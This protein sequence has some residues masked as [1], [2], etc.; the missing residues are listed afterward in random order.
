[1]AVAGI[2]KGS[3]VMLN[4]FSK[5]QANTGFIVGYKTPGCEVMT[6][7]CQCPNQDQA[8]AEVFRLNAS[9]I[10][11]AKQIRYDREL[12]G[13]GGVYPELVGV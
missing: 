9:Q 13:L 5:P 7:V 2:L 6:V 8:D 1:M 4:Y 11:K 10:A 12:R 3:D